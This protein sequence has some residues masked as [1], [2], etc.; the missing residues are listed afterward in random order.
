MLPPRLNANC[1]DLY[2]RG[3]WEGW[4]DTIIDVRVTN[5]DSK[6]DKNLPSKKALERERKEILQAL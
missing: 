2:I 3:F 4:A 6:F 1:D 5:L